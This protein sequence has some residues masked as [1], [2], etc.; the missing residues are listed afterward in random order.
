MILIDA[1]GIPRP[2][3]FRTRESPLIPQLRLSDEQDLFTEVVVNGTE[4]VEVK[5]Q[6]VRGGVITGRVVTDDDQPLP[7]AD[8]K[9]LRKQ[10][11]KW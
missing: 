5:I 2:Q 9:L 7:K 6:A 1:P 4:T 8:V 11:G 10:N 3:G